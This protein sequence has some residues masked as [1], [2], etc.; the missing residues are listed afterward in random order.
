MERRGLEERPRW[1]RRKRAGHTNNTISVIS[2]G[3]SLGGKKKP[4]LQDKKKKLNYLEKGGS[5][6]PLVDG[7]TCR[8]GRGGDG[9]MSQKKE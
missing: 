5:I 1:P 8:F 2:R 3:K 4:G 9:V 6:G 7:V